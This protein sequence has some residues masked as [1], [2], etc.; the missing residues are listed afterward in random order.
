MKTTNFDRITAAILTALSGDLPA[1]RRPWRTLRENGAAPIPM[2]AVSG[3]AYRGINTVILWGRQDAD[4]R[5][6]TFRQAKQ[7]GGHVRKGEKGTQIVFWMKRQ[8]TAKNDETGEDEKRDSLLMRLYTVFN[9]AQC[10]GLKF[11][12]R[13]AAP[14]PQQAPQSM[15]EI[16]SK[17]GATVQHG[18]DRAFF[19]PGPDVIGMPSAEAFTSA[20][21]Y[22]ATAL[23]ELVH[24]TGHE[25]RLAREFGK[26]FGD[27]AYAAEE[28]VAEIGSA[29]LCAALGINSALEHHASYVQHWNQLLRDDSRAVIT[30]ASRAQAAAD[31][32]LGRIQQTAEEL[33]DEEVEELAMAA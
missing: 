26:R 11:S 3:R 18:G 6:L 29:F 5:Y 20:D 2:N 27:R 25:Q 13:K 16:Y 21:A 24:W 12:E 22:A 30:A 23:H 33:E 31:Y 9:V 19:A 8:F 1:W 28:L 17:L 4:M 14:A 15:T 32:L 7:L 10:E